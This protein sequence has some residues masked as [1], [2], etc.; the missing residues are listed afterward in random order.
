MKEKK[1]FHLVEC[2]MKPKI[3]K[4]MNLV[5]Q[6]WT[7]V[8]CASYN[9]AADVHNFGHYRSWELQLD[10]FFVSLTLSG[11]LV[12]FHKLSQVTFFSGCVSFGEQWLLLSQ[13]FRP[14]I[15]RTCLRYHKSQGAITYIACLRHLKSQRAITY[16]ACLRHK[17]LRAITYIAC[18][19][20][21][22][23]QRAITYIACLR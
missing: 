13:K 21:L 14:T 6:F 11:C 7:L 16:I 19:R 23:S 10:Y 5:K 15:V 8:H 2:K 4:G 12:R 20:Y 9:M 17:C 18:L 22:K 1:Y 3:W